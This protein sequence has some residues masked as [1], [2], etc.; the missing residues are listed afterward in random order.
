M[1]FSRIIRVCSFAAAVLVGFPVAT[2]GI[3]YL[4]DG[5][6]GSQFINTNNW[7][8]AGEPGAADTA[9]FRLGAV[10]AYPV[11]LFQGLFDPINRTVDRMIVGANTVSFAGG[12]LTVDSTNTTETGRGL[13]IGQTASD[14]AVVNSGLQGLSTVY[15]T[16]GSAAGSSGTLNVT[17][18]TFNVTGG[19][20]PYELIVGLFG[21]GAINVGGGRDVNISD[22][23]MLGLYSGSN[24]TATV[25]GVG[26]TWANGGDVFVGGAGSGAINITDGGQLT[27][28]R[29]DIATETGGSGDVNVTGPNSTLTTNNF[30]R[31]A[32][33]DGGTGSLD[34]TA[35]GSVASG[36]GYVGYGGSAMFGQTSV[37]TALVDGADSNWT[38][39]DPLNV[40]SYNATGT[41]TISNGGRV[42]SDR[43]FIGL[44]GGDLVSD[45]SVG[46]VNVTGSTSLWDNSDDLY[47]GRGPL[48]DGTLNITSGGRVNNLNAYVGEVNG[49]TG[50]VTVDGLNS[51][52]NNIGILQVGVAGSGTLAV[53]N[54][55]TVQATNITINSLGEARGNGT[56][57]GNVENRGLVAPGTSL[58]TLDVTGNYTQFVDGELLVELA[59]AASYD[60]LQI[61]GI[62]MLDGTL[63]VSLLGG[64]TPDLGD[65]FGF[66]FAS[67]GFGGQFA[68]LSLPNLTPGL[69]WQ[70]NPGGAT[71]FLNV[72]AGLLGDYNG[73]NV[74]DAADYTVWRDHLGQ[75][76]TLTNENPAAATPGLVDVEDYAFWKTH[77]GETAGSGSATQ[78][79][80][81]PEPA[82]ISLLIVGVT[83]IAWPCRRRSTYS[84]GFI[85]GSSI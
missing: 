3:G 79:A 48:S 85:A 78:T 55:G 4:W 57:V 14:V 35:G 43:G 39:S 58:G 72:V 41:L 59:S 18:G 24:G 64:F 77:F 45:R 25:S 44:D 34:V 30:G 5:S 60:R 2:H 76:F 81:V 67:G 71:L 26:S 50:N 51:R 12:V 20:T 53:T 1:K 6:S 47:M 27:A 33:G 70:L 29:V 83:A 80:A 52:W 62:A 75:S 68:S 31:I 37:G 82:P 65:S 61:T 84:S 49:S 8:P 15:A 10:P 38:I 32:V 42:T 11:L 63:T 36:T 23:T 73:N 66:L 22:D 13:I 7:T 54:A 21:S 17:N 9:T 69:K 40:G 16:F 74:I 28:G 56:L 19:M 46:T